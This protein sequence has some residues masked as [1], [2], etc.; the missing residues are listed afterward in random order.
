MAAHGSVE[1]LHSIQDRISCP[2]FWS[3]SSG[4]GQRCVPGHDRAGN[5]HE[6]TNIPDQIKTRLR[7]KGVEAGP[8]VGCHLPQACTT[9]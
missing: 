2:S 8:K 7:D 6:P 9:Y 5:L 4:P 1:R 3:P